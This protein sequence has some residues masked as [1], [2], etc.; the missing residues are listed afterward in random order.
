[1]TVISP[2]LMCVQWDE[3]LGAGR[4]LT[5]GLLVFYLLGVTGVE[6]AR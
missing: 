3:Q 5:F 2:D 4:A 6:K 1:M